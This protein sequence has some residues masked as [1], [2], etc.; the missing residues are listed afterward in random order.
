MKLT[1]QGLF[2]CTSRFKDA[3]S[4]AQALE[5]AACWEE[6]AQAA[7]YHL[8]IELGRY[9]VGGEHFVHCSVVVPSSEVEMYAGRGANSLSIVGRLSTL[10]SV[11]YRRFLSLQQFVPIVTS[12][13]WPWSIPCNKCRYTKFPVSFG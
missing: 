2:L 13:M 9:T 1:K 11:H 5:V 7:L 12:R 6:L 10:Q 4:Y 3:W 8:D